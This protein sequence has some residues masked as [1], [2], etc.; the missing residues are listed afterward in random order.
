VWTHGKRKFDKKQQGEHKAVAWEVDDLRTDDADQGLIFIFDTKHDLDAAV[1]HKWVIMVKFKTLL[2][3][4]VECNQHSLLMPS[5]IQ[6][7]TGC[8]G[9]F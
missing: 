2:T 8:H 4:I 3:N 6:I 5:S 1:R 9:S 7:F